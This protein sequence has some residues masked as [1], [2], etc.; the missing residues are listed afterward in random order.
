MVRL[1]ENAPEVLT[2]DSEHRDDHAREERNERRQRDETGYG[3]LPE[4]RVRNQNETV[5]HADD[6]DE[7]A[8]AGNHSD[9]RHREA[10]QGVDEELEPLPEGP[11]R[12]AMLPLLAAVMDHIRLVAEPVREQCDVDVLA[13]LQ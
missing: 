4:Q 12:L 8:E 10:D 5:N 2:D 13:A 7:D 6:R 9:R 11:A 3:G 1:V